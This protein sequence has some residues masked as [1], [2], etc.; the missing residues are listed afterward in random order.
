M[1]IGC[2]LSSARGFAAMGHDAL[3]IGANTFQYFTRNPRGGRAKPLDLP[4]VQALLALAKASGFG[5]LVAH[6]PYTLNAC[7]AEERPQAFARMCMQEDLARLEALPGSYYNLH[8]G[9]HVGQGVEAGIEQTSALLNEL[10][11]PAQSTTVLLETMSGQGSEIGGTFEQLAELIARIRQKARIGVCLDTCHVFAAGYDVKND[12]DGVLTRFDKTVGL[13]YLKAVHL[14]DSMQ[15]LGSGRDRHQRIGLGEIG[16]AAI[17]RI[18]AHAA[19]KDLPFILET[20][21]ELDGHAAEIRLLRE[22]SAQPA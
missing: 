14:N 17:R 10:T 21:N 12:L 4:D 19:L 9:S 3:A 18:L 5:A 20:P 1:F 7:A 11:T 15:P 8:P 16:L 13:H 6:A 22:P 2:H